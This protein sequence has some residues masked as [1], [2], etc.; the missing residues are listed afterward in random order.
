MIFGGAVQTIFFYTCF[1][2]LAMGAIFFEFNI[3]FIKQCISIIISVVLCF[4]LSMSKVIPMFMLSK[5][6]DRGALMISNIKIYEIFEVL[7]FSF[8]L[9][10]ISFIEKIFFLNKFLNIKYSSIH[11]KDLSLPFI[12]MLIIIF[13]IILN[14]KIIINNIKN[15]NKTK[16]TKLVLIFIFTYI[17]IDM[18]YDKGITHSIF[19]ILN[20]IN[21]YL[22]L[23]STTII[24]I[25]IL[26]CYLMHNYKLFNRNKEIILL[27]IINIYTIV[28]FIYKHYDNFNN[29]KT[30]FAS[31]NIDDGIN[32][33]KKINNLGSNNNYKVSFISNVND[34]IILNQFLSN[35]NLYSSQYPYEPIYGYELQTFKAKEEGSIYQEKDNYFNFTHPNSLLL[36]DENYKQFTGFKISEKDDL[37]KFASFKKVNWKLPKLFTI[38]NNI[39]ILSYIII[40]FIL[41]ILIILNIVLYLKKY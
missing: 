27:L 1:T 5:R 29:E 9:P 25:I 34:Y 20:K 31:L 15:Y 2:L 7:Y 41:V 40:S 18:Y 4:T 22:R 30:I 13:I 38:A 24:P 32:V 23:A 14:K 6:I 10:I 36:F 37:I 33:W 3:K 16:K 21:L 8:I 28:F 39:S 35:D 19:P 11:E 12:L 26:I 17:F